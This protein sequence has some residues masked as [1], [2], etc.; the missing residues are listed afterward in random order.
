MLFK[1]CDYVF[2]S[3]FNDFGPV[4]V[5]DEETIT[6]NDAFVHKVSFYFVGDLVV[7]YWKPAV[8]TTI[9]LQRPMLYIISSKAYSITNLVFSTLFVDC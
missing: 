2:V 5:S 8:K 4:E 7:A 1:T 9:G 6:I 3:V